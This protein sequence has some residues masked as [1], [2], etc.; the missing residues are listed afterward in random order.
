MTCF[1]SP[2]FYF[3]ISLVGVGQVVLQIAAAT[4]CKLAF[5]IEKAEVPAIYSK[6]GIIILSSATPTHTHSAVAFIPGYKEAIKN[7]ITC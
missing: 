7:D 6:V 4:P 2:K 5:G 1:K 3:C